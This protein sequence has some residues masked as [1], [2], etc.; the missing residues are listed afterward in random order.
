MLVEEAVNR[1]KA[2]GR[3]TN[4]NWGVDR[5]I[6]FIN[7]ALQQ[8]S[9]LLVSNRYPPIVNTIQLHNGD[10]LPE[11]YMYAA[12][13]YP[14]RITNGSVEFLDEDREEIR[15]RYFAS[16]GRVEKTSDT[17]PFTNDAI[18]EVVI[19]GAVLLALN[20]NAYQIGQD[21]QLVAALQ[22]AVA[23]GLSGQG[24]VTTG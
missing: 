4:Q 20:E 6:D 23:S 13:T 17:M 8:V 18:N 7:T 24:M 10:S 3:G 2:A 5:V 14:I 12:G 1:I 19:K 22:Q 15:F 11:N 21:S 16:A 9:A